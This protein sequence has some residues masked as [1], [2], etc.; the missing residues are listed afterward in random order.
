M[1]MTAWHRIGVVIVAAGLMAGSVNAQIKPGEYVGTG[2]RGT[3][4]VMP[5]KGDAMRFKLNTVGGN[6]H[7]CDLEGVIR[8]GE[9]RM[10]E[11]A[12]DKLPCIVTFTS[13]KQGIEVASRH[14]GT[15]S[16]YCG[17]RA[18]FEGSYTLPPPECAPS[19]VRRSRDQ[20]KAQFDKKFY[21]QARAL[22]TPIVEKCTSLLNDY[23]EGW[24]RNDLALTQHR[25]GDSAACRATLLRLV[26]LA[27]Q[28]DELIKE[29]Y[30]PSEA[31]EMLR[32]ARATRYNMK[33][34]GAPI[35][36]G[37]KSAR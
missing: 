32:I 36:V 28:P 33:L 5:D 11:S 4:R 16:T 12:N 8:R 29:G 3:L 15:C 30:P 7:V 22:L 19:E 1:T 2:G 25:A 9:A 6:F 13:T 10:D 34:C 27:R 17:M 26:D 21:T 24:V 23:D 20:F 35:A 31:E 37:G 14:Q 18:H